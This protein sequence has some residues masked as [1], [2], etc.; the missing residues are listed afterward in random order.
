[1]ESVLDRLV[2]GQTGFRSIAFQ[3]AEQ[4]QAGVLPV[5]SNIEGDDRRCQHATCRGARWVD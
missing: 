1:M 4:P 3:P 5:G 2:G